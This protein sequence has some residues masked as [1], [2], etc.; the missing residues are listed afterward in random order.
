MD[1]YRGAVY[2]IPHSLQK[3]EREMRQ[4]QHSQYRLYRLKAEINRQQVL[5][6]TRMDTG[7]ASGD[8]TRGSRRV[9]TG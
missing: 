8:V 1:G 5:L 4:R 3:S 2:R 6:D 9:M 7:G